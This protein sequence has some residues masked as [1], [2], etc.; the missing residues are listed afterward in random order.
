MSFEAKY[1]G[2]CGS[3]DERIRVGELVAYDE[4]V[5][6]HAECESAARMI[7]KADVCTG[8]WLTKPCDCEETQ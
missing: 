5:I 1:G 3:C 2:T 7:R 8:C 4:D 6:V